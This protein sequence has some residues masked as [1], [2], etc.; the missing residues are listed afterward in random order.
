MTTPNPPE[1]S[2]TGVSLGLPSA[3][4]MAATPANE[5]LRQIMDSRVP[6]NER[7][8][9]AARKIEELTRELATERAASA[10]ALAESSG[11]VGQ[12]GKKAY[13]LALD[14]AES[15]KQL[16]DLSAHAEALA[17]ALDDAGRYLYRVAHFEESHKAM[18]GLARYLAA[19]EAK[20][21]AA[22]GNAT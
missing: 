4:A 9:Y 20:S 19:T 22:G 1:P 16:A 2:P 17:E 13:G 8:W 15:K 5:L 11:R 14:L 6:K 7:E 21:K 18:S 10:L 3:A 12:I